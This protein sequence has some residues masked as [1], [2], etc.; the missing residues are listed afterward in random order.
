MTAILPDTKTRESMKAGQIPGSWKYVPMPV[1]E[2]DKEHEAYLA[3]LKRQDQAEH[4]ATFRADPEAKTKALPEGREQDRLYAERQAERGIEPIR[5]NAPFDRQG[6]VRS[7]VRQGIDKAP[8]DEV[9][10]RTERE[11][12]ALPNKEETPNTLFRSHVKRKKSALGLTAFGPSFRVK[13]GN[14]KKRKKVAEPKA[15]KGFVT[16]L[17]EHLK[18]YAQA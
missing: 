1:P 16:E 17:P 5:P 7:L 10:G 2:S 13:G 15:R 4:R 18:Q 8:V 9:Y 12:A 3:T 6:A 11:R 14:R